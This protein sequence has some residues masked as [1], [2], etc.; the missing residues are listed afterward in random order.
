M[1]TYLFS[2][3][4]LLAFTL[5]AQ[6]RKGNF[7]LSGNTAL[8]YSKVERD[9]DQLSGG[10]RVSQRVTGLRFES[11]RSGYFLTNR[12][13]VGARADYAGVSRDQ[14]QWIGGRTTL[15]FQP[16]VRYYFLDLGARPLSVF[17]EL[18]FGTVGVGDGS[19]FETD[20]HLGLGAELTLAP[21]ILGTANLNYDAYAY[22]LNYTVLNLGLNV[23]T[24]QLR[25]TTKTASVGAGTL[26]AAGQLASLAYGR[27][28]SGGLAESNLL[29]RLSP[30]VGYLVLDGLLVEADLGV[31]YESYRS[32]R[33]FS[34]SFFGDLTTADLTA[35]VRGRYYFLQRSRL[36]P[37]AGAG[38]GYRRLRQEVGGLGNSV[39]RRSRTSTW[40][41]GAGAAYFF[42]PQLALDL[43]VEY[44]SG[45]GRSASGLVAAADRE[46]GGA[47]ALRFFLPR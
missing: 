37:F 12:L 45:T 6:E 18:G 32:E 19:G 36:L 43:T 15:A 22:G 46:W 1:K 42:S 14:R 27:T 35:G 16:F 9:L 5:T 30:R 40:R 24:G 41:L 44:N 11:F 2:L 28:A 7:Y 33:D 3:C 4:M 20:F 39:E 8:Q 31:S 23:L 21:G 10:A 26:T 47:L 34:S 38:I 29:V 25:G 17:G 13:L